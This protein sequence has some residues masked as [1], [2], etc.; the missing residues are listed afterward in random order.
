MSM[1]GGDKKSFAWIKKWGFTLIKILH[2]D[3]FQEQLAH[4][5]PQGVEGEPDYLIQ[6]QNFTT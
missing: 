3:K 5:L 6:I 1:E 4:K 2:T